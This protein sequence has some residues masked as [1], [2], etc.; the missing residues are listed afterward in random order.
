MP[1][2]VFFTKAT[3]VGPSQ[4]KTIDSPQS[5]ALHSEQPS[6]D[7][8][9][10]VNAQVERYEESDNVTEENPDMVRNR[11]NAANRSELYSTSSTTETY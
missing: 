2:E 8:K 9:G 1:S 10:R 4:L 3:S 6:L 5:Q 11:T 7:V